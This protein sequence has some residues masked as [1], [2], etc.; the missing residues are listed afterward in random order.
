MARPR[1]KWIFF[2]P[3]LQQPA[4]GHHAIIYNCHFGRISLL[5]FSSSGN[6]MTSLMTAQEMKQ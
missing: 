5:S 3:P 2:N 6:P 4:W 1:V